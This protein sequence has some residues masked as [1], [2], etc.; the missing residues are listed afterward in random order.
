MDKHYVDKRVS[1]LEQSIEGLKTTVSML[2]EVV[3]TKVDTT[4]V[5]L[6][7]KQS[8]VVKK[9]NESEGSVINETK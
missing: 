5:Q 8:E 2:S 3:K 6:I 4:D 1:E 9:I 7:I